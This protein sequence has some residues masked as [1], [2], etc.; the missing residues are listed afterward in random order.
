MQ[1]Y[2]D[3]IDRWIK[4]NRATVDYSMRVQGCDLGRRLTDDDRRLWAVNDQELY[5]KMRADGALK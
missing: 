4:R 2:T 3:N 5:L 1:N